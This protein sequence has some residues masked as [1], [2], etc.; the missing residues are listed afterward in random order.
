MPHINSLHRKKKLYKPVR[1]DKRKTPSFSD[2]ST[3]FRM[4]QE[5]MQRYSLLRKSKACLILYHKLT[6]KIITKLKQKQKEIF[7]D[8]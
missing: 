3:E 5:I 2:K 6:T 1:L 8:V 4:L 7:K